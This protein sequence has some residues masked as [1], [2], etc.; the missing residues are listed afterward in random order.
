[1]TA[2]EGAIGAASRRSVTPGAD[3]ESDAGSL[4]PATGRKSGA[5]AASLAAWRASTASDCRLATDLVAAAGLFPT[6]AGIEAPV[7]AGIGRKDVELGGCPTSAC[8]TS[9]AGTATAIP[10]AALRA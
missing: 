7:A 4:R 6:L 5:R 10:T 3:R 2:R 1:M 8:A 9:I